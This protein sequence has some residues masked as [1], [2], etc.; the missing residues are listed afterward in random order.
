[1]LISGDSHVV[2][3]PTLWRENLPASLCGRAPYA[4]R[5]PGNHHWYF[6]DPEGFRGVDLT[7]SATAGLP[8]GER[9]ARLRADPDADIEVSGA[10]DPVARL[11]DLWRDGTVADVIY[12]TATLSLM[13]LRDA[14]LQGACFRVYND[15]IADYCSVDRERL[16]G[17]GVLPCW[18]ID[19]AV[20]ELQRCVDLGLR[21][22]AIWTSP[23]EEE[24]FFDER[25]EPLWAAA[26][27]A[28][29]PISLHTLAG[30]RASREIAGYGK[31]V[32]ST[33]FFGF[34]TRL[35]LQRSLCELIVSGVFE[36]HSGLRVVAAEGGIEYAATLERRLDGGHAKSW[37][38]LSH[39]LSMKP[40]K[41]F[42]RN[43]FLTYI[44]DPVGL[45]NI[46]FTG[47][48]HFLWSGDYP[49]DASTWPNSEQKL[50][51][52]C[53]A[54]GLDDTAIEALTCTNTAELYG[55][56]LAVVAEPSPTIEATVSP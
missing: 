4:E 56:D 47:S 52:E 24:S 42:R 33:F 35:E 3:P 15:W 29:M 30:N 41:Y 10:R 14:T 23:P 55:F 37:G 43:V 50:R 25:Y 34:T 49:H 36:R 11:R 16:A 1:M 18:N 31:S 39:E 51:A 21:G 26:A 6:I 54:A 45:N 38:H 53:E 13:G 9:D 32:E 40:S 44:S 2:E 27:E 22:A 17:L 20:T 48:S 12:P 28:R 8:A 19:A 5:D 7:A 46:R